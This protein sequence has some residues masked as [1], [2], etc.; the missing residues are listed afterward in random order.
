M[1]EMNSQDRAVQHGLCW[2]RERYG[3]DFVDRYKAALTCVI[4]DARSQDDHVIP[5]LQEK[6]RLLIKRRGRMVVN[7]R[8]SQPPVSWE[9]S[10]GRVNRKQNNSDNQED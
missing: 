4:I 6:I 2:A 1:A 8:V 5:V 9:P 10:G 7:K 3:D